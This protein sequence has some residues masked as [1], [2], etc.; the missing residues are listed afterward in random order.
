MLE[1]PESPFEAGL[2]IKAQLESKQIKYLEL[3]SGGEKAFVALLFLFAIQACNP[4]SIYVLDEADAAL[5][6]HNSIKLAELLKK[7]A[8]TTQ[9]IV[10]THNDDVYKNAD[11]LVGVS[12][13][14]GGSQIVEVKLNEEKEERSEEK[15]AEKKI[16]IP[17][18]L[19]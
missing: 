1:N 3:M 8:R 9:F 17:E 6:Q 7:L 2:T 16:E 10:V 15:K 12:M 5:D 19:K 11:C 13:A 14:R 18:K 4:S